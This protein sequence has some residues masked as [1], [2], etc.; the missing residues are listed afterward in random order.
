MTDGATS[1]ADDKRRPPASTVRCFHDGH[2]LHPKGRYG[3]YADGRNAEP[4]NATN[5]WGQ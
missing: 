5:D 4:C 3:T 2:L 1:S